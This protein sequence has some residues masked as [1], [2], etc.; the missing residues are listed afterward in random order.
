MIQKSYQKNIINVNHLN[1]S[2]TKLLTNP[3]SNINL[4]LNLNKS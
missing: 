1:K 3:N 4:N 2:P